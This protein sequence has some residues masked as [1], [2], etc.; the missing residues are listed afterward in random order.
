VPVPEIFQF[1][2]LSNLSDLHVGEYL[3]SDV[4]VV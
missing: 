3:Y 2:E 1:G 4:I